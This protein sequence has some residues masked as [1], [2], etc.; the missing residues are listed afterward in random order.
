MSRTL[1]CLS[2]LRIWAGALV[3]CVAAST[4]TA[5]A[6]VDLSVTC[7]GAAGDMRA[8]GALPV[9]CVYEPA[10]GY[11]PT[12]DGGPWANVDLLHSSASDLE[13]LRTPTSAGDPGFYIVH[14][15]ICLSDLRP[16]FIMPSPYV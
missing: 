6:H 8:E 11:H 13:K 3:I 10:P 7:N 12:H 15:Q 4:A 9:T 16:R 2:A 5:K 1:S 14:A